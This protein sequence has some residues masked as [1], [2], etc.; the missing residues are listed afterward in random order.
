[1]CFCCEQ[2]VCFKDFFS[3]DCCFV[4]HHLKLR[5][6]TVLQHVSVEVETCRSS[7]DPDSFNSRAE[8]FNSR[9]WWARLT[10]LTNQNF[11]YLSL[12]STYCRI[13][14]TMITWST[15]RSVA[16]QSRSE[17]RRVFWLH[18]VVF[19]VTWHLEYVQYTCHISAFNTFCAY[20]AADIM[21]MY[22]FNLWDWTLWGKNDYLA[23]DSCSFRPFHLCSVGPY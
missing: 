22:F 10:L 16:E 17:R 13:L 23:L 2:R 6:T 3:L 4:G 12:K 5:F 19:V 20:T 8:I 14:I 21:C 11:N 15:G 1:M 18:V 7:F 9:S